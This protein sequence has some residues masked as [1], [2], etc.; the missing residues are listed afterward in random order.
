MDLRKEKGS[1]QKEL[2]DA[3]AVSRPTY[4][5]WENDSGDLPITKLFLLSK[6]YKISINKLINMICSENGIDNEKESLN[7]ELLLEDLIHIKDVLNKY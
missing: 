4:V 3:L 1:S 6:F 5:S 2:A 7:K